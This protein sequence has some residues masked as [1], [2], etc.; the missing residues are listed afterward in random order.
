MKLLDYI[1]SSIYIFMSIILIT[2]IIQIE[3]EKYLLA[4]ICIAIA[5]LYISREKREK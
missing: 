4:G 2:E 3:N 1:V 5:D